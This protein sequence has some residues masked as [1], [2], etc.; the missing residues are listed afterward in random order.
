MKPKLLTELD[1]SPMISLA[2]CR[3]HL[4]IT[5]DDDSPTLYPDD[6]LVL[7]MLG[8][9]REWVEGYT[10]LALTPRTLE[11][12]LDVFP[13]SEIALFVAPVVAI[14][15]VKYYI[16]G[17]QQTISSSNYVLDDYQQPGWLLPASGYTWPACDD[18]VNAVKI[19]YTAGYSAWDDSPQSLPLPKALRAAVL[20]ILGSLYENRENTTNVRVDAVPYGATSLCDMWRVRKGFA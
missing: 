4:R 20:L 9:A 16:D 17:V 15:S 14:E 18:V 12:A 13:A 7:A 10:G 19:R 6:D 8:A 3:A 5:G 11:L 1:A 2:D